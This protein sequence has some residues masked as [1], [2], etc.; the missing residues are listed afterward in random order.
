MKPNETWTVADHGPL[1]KLA[2]NL[3]SVTATMPMPLG[4]T[5]RRM[6]I[7]KLADGR[8]VVFSA[9]SLDETA[10]A[11]IDALGR[12]AFIVVP[13]GIHRMDITGWTHRYPQAR[14]IAPSGVREK[15]EELVKVDA[16]AI[17]LSDRRVKISAVPGTGEQ[18]LAMLVTTDRK[19]TLVVADL[20][21][22][23]PRL[24]GFAQF[25]YRLLGFGPGHPTQPPLV[26]M[27]LVKDKEAMREQLRAW[28]NDSGLERIL[29]AHGAPIEN[30]RETLLELAA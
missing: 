23:L 21:F 4:E 27:S 2:E 16:C 25:A 9:I 19:K 11:K 13:S 29:V 5:V 30:P 28:A 26:R 3:Y 15:V 20:I 8:L 14:V 24:H 10:M 6:T 7:A 22:N 12:V 1:E 18:E 17:E